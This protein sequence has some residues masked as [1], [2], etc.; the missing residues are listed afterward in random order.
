MDQRTSQY[1]F[2]H[3][4]THIL[5]LVYRNT[6]FRV[7]RRRSVLCGRRV[8][9]ANAHTSHFANALSEIFNA[10][11]LPA[12]LYNS[13]RYLALACAILRCH[14]HNNSLFSFSSSFF[15]VFGSGAIVS[16]AD[17]DLVISIAFA[18][19]VLNDMYFKPS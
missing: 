17:F 16:D 6:V 5:D 11:I 9:F 14:T 18:S 4:V 8:D 1:I 2:F 12:F 3:Q 13:R 10:G 19:D 15:P 7:G